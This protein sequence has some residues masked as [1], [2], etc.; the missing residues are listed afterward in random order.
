M[1][2]KCVCNLCSGQIEFEN[3]AAG[4]FI[5]CP[6]CGMETLLFIPPGERRRSIMEAETK[7][8]DSIYQEGNVT[9]SQTILKVGLSTYPIAAISSFRIVKL[10]PNKKI[11]KTLAVVATVSF[12]FGLFILGLVASEDSS[13]PAATAWGWIFEASSIGIFA[14]LIISAIVPHVGQMLTGKTPF[15]LSIT[16][17]AREQ[18]AVTSPNFETI[19]VIEAALQKA[20]SLRG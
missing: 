16:T 15:G 8:T 9:V 12:I 1:K 14:L 4:Q 6:H 11:P 10:P 2:S 17:S 3:S 13:P 20:V 19:R 18:I 5:I 7:N